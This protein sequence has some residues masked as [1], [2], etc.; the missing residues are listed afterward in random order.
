MEKSQEDRIWDLKQ[1]NIR[2]TGV[3]QE[4]FSALEKVVLALRVILYVGSVAFAWF[5]LKEHAMAVVIAASL[6]AAHL[7]IF[8]LEYV[9]EKKQEVIDA[10]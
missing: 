3:L 7:L 10:K 5:Y 2:L 6:T 8:F 9:R 4:L 1:K